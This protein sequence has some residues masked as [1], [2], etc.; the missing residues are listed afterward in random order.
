MLLSREDLELK[1]ED[2]KTDLDTVEQ[3][4]QYYDDAK[5]YRQ[6]REKIN[7]IETDS[8]LLDRLEAC[9]TSG[10]AEILMNF[11]SEK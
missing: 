8:Y 7:E 1:L 5:K 2:N 4:L 6:L 9:D 11:L 10:A 3:I